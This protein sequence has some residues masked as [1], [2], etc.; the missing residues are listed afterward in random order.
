MTSQLEFNSRA[1]LCREFA[2]REPG[3]RALWMAEAESWSRREQEPGDTVATGRDQPVG[4][5]QRGILHH[6]NWFCSKGTGR[7][8]RSRQAAG[9][10]RKDP[11]EEFLDLMAIE[12]GG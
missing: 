9:I 8:S 3:C 6:C 1:A 5:Y 7:H 12:D 11:F 2:R 10:V 4:S